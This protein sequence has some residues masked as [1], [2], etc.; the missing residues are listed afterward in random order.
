MPQPLH[1]VLRHVRQ[2]A[3]NVLALGAIAG[4]AAVAA[5]GRNRLPPTCVNT[6]QAEKHSFIGSM[7]IML[8][9]VAAIAIVWETLPVLLIPAC[10]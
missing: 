4:I 6:M 1:H 2:H 3:G 7:T 8:G 9:M 10:A 5:D